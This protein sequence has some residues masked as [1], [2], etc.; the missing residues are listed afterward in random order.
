MSYRPEWL[1]SWPPDGRP[2][3]SHTGHYLY[4]L[5]GDFLQCGSLSAPTLTCVKTLGKVWD[6]I[7]KDA[8]IFF[9]SENHAD[10]LIS[11]ITISHHQ[12]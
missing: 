4:S 10:E 2:D 1:G 11:L 12:N 7:Y 9:T 6:Q 5:C 3:I 8:Q